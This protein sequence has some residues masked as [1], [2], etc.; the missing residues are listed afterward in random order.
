MTTSN[1]TADGMTPRDMTA[2]G[3][4]AAEVTAAAHV[5]APAQ[6]ASRRPVPRLG[7]AAIAAAAFFLE[8]AVS[9]RY[10]YV[11]DELYFLAAG[12]HLAFGFVDQPALTPLIARISAELT[13]NSLVGLRIVP[14][15]GL[16]ALVVM[17]AAMSR[18]LGAGRTGQLLAAFAAA[19][20]GEYVGA[21]HELTTTVPDFL[22]WALTLLLV[23]RLLVSQDPRWWIAIGVCAGIASE[24]KWN[25]AFLVAALAAGFLATDAR[26]LLRSRYVVAGCVLAA[27]LAV[28]DLA[29]QAAHGWPNLSVFHALQSEAWQNRATYWPAQVLFTGLALTPVWISGLVWTLRNPRARTFRPIAIACGLAIVLQFVL[30]GKP[31][32]PGGAYTFLLAAGSVPAERWLHARAG[33]IRR[34]VIALLISAAGVLPVALPVLP[35]A[36]LHTIPLQKINYDLAESIAWPKQ[37]ALVAHEYHAL[38]AALRK[39]TTVITEN[40]GEAGAIDRYGA[41]FGLPQVFSGANSFWLWGPP[42]ASATAAIAVNIDPGLLRREFTSVRLIAVFHNGLGVSDDEQGARIYL[43]TGLRTPWSKTW[44]AFRD[45]S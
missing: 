36:A 16:A 27:A 15:L 34:A 43:A 9:G 11:R 10:G 7:I 19:S 37:V 24:A 39:H 42:P 41:Q 44:R 1:M 38:P 17:T 13:G 40:Y 6:G 23:T 2:A 5:Q 4:T 32:Y 25:I 31:Y 14:A 20:C 29:W 21:M 45:Y 22:F 18:L 26:R 8:L 35:A 30:G 33:R 12:K 28:P 3:S